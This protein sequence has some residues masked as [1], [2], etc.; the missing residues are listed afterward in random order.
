MKV[1]HSKY[2]N[3]G[4]LF[5]LLTR[6]LT[7]DTI[8]G[9]NP[10]ALHIIKKDKFWS[11]LVLTC[12]SLQKTGLPKIIDSI[13]D[14]QNESKKSGFFEDNRKRQIQRWLKSL[15]QSELDHYIKNDLEL[16]KKLTSSETKVVNGEISASQGAK[17]MLNY[18]LNH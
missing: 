14:F 12:S 8:A 13:F 11:P 16:K 5:E 17:E 3:T 6:Q 18:L 10:K 1:K 7:A 2:K 4:I 15:F 9:S